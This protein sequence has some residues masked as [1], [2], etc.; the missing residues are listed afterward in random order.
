MASSDGEEVKVGLDDRIPWVVKYR[1]RR[2]EEVVGQDE[3][4]R[5]LREWLKQWA[6]GRVPERRAAL[7][8]GPPG[9][10]KTS[11]VEALAKEFDFDVLELNASDY[12]RKSDIERTV[13]VAARKKPLF[14]KG[15]LILMDEVDGI[16]PK[17]D[18]GGI[19]AL[20]EVV[21]V[22]GNPTHN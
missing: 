18:E 20:V 19:E 8:H 21:K 17:A 2:V 7:L 9:V 22:T 14:K 16:D 3:A 12:R 10:G 5:V 6:E 4:K 1:P 15:L 13:S 11:L